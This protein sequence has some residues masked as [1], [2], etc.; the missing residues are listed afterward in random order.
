MFHIFTLPVQGNTIQY[1]QHV[2]EDKLPP[3]R[4]HQVCPVLPSSTIRLVYIEPHSSLF[5]F[6]SENQDGTLW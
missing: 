2:E 1:S 4:Q 5:Y 3:A 6:Q